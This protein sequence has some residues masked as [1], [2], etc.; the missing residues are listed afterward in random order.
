MS[1]QTEKLP[2]SV[3]GVPE[4]RGERERQR[5][6]QNSRSLKK[7]WKAAALMTKDL[8]DPW[9]GLGFDEITEEV[10]TRHMYNPRS[11][12]WKSDEVVVRIQSK[13]RNQSINIVI[14]S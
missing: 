14:A 6:F 3:V 12:K 10:V 7:Q 2:S 13:V 9:E 1:S 5:H 8:P 11:S 4:D